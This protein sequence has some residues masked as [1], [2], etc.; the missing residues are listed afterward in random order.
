MWFVS[1]FFLLHAFTSLVSAQLPLPN[2][3]FLPPNASVG[4]QPSSSARYPNSQWT[5]LLGNLLYFYEAQRSGYLP[6]N[7][8][9]PWRNASAVD[10]GIV[11]G[12]D[13]TGMQNKLSSPRLLA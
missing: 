2:P 6:S 11:V 9:V 4:A 5:T 12:T 7:N 13:L 10:D 8:R 3:P 1:L